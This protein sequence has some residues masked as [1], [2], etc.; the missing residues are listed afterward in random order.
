[1]AIEGDEHR[2]ETYDKFTVAG[3]A[4]RG[5]TIDA[6]ALWADLDKFADDLHDVAVSDERYGVFFEFDQGGEE[7][8]YLVGHEVEST[9]SLPP[10]LT[11]VEI[12]EGR[13]ATFTPE[14]RTHDQI[15]STINEELLSDTD[16]EMQKE[17]VFHRYHTSDQP[18]GLE[19]SSEWFVPIE[20]E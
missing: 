18:S 13:Y 19:G 14:N 20:E 5:T 9:D 6:K 11:A 2:V 1:M 15:L 7:V 3:V 16:H 12:P 4:E 8:T 10:Q 17:L